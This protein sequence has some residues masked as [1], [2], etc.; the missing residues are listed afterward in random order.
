MFAEGATAVDSRL[1][2]PDG[3]PVN[4]RL[5]QTV[6]SAHARV[7]DPLD[8]VVENDVRVGGLTVIRAGSAA[9]GSVLSV[10]H[11]RMLG[12]GG[13]IVLG[14]NSIVLSSGETIGLQARKVVKG[15]SHTWR[16]I[17][18]MAVTALFYL[19]A[20]PLLLLTRGSASTALKGT[21]ITAKI[22]CNA[23][24]QTADLPRVG[25][26]PA[27][28]DDM[29]NNLPPRVT[30]REGREGDMVNL[31]FVAQKSDLQAAFDRA[32]WVKTDGWNPKMA[33][34][35]LTQRTH[36]ARLPMA[37]F[38]MFGRVQDYSYALPD[39]N[40]V[41][42]RRHHI[43]IWK[44]HY[45]VNGYPVWAAAASYDQAIEFAKAGRIINHTIDPQVDTER[46]FVGTDLAETSELHKTY[47]QSAN[48]VFNAETVAGQAYYSDSRIL[49][50]DIQQPAAVAAVLA[51]ASTWTAQAMPTAAGGSTAML[52]SRLK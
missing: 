13:N 35:L 43:R 27:G 22:D 30:N 10:R 5:T 31:V 49:M 32:G 3:T 40:A 14:L 48:P 45:T 24:V 4:L 1:A 21:E 42:S 9:R 44:S 19:P 25:Q 39:P 50:L 17:T 7:G 18:G 28:M 23:F 38:Y 36:D 8:F 51:G 47:L 26:D 29:M 15:G 46:D 2:I 16:M 33:W 20:A 34:H 12:I 37:R 52:R 6:S 41:V 11:P